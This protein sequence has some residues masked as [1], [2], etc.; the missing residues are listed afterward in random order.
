[1]GKLF[2]QRAE[3]V[4]PAHTRRREARARLLYDAAWTYRAAGAD[5][6]PAYTALLAQFPDL[7]LAVEARLELAELV[8]EKKPDEAIKLLKAAIDKEPTDKPTPPETLDRIRI[9]LGV[10]LFDKKDYAGGTGA[11][12]RGG[13]QRQVAAPRRTGCT[14]PRSACW[15]SARPTTRRRS[16]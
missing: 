15:R 6:V 7:S 10:A 3:T 8:A 1:M 4:P 16:W 2:E 12:R 9:R 13:E 14:A 5:P 11:V